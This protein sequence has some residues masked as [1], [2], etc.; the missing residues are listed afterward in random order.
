MESINKQYSLEERLIPTPL[1]IWL[2]MRD[3]P[4]IF[5]KLLQAILRRKQASLLSH[6]D[7]KG[8]STVYS[9]SSVTNHVVNV[10]LQHAPAQYQ[11]FQKTPSCREATLL[12]EAR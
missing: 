3:C 10:A 1:K 9:V 2:D 12:M 8:T 11:L 5:V 7:I 4:T 6:L